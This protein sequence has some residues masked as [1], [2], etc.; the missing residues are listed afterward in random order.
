MDDYLERADLDASLE[1]LRTHKLA[2]TKK[3]G[4]VDDMARNVTDNVDDYV[5]VRDSIVWRDGSRD[6]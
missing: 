4:R 5:V 1:D 6:A 3:S 2:F